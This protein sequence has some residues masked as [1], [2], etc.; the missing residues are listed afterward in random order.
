MSRSSTTITVL[1]IRALQPVRLSWPSGWVEV[2]GAAGIPPL[3]T[4]DNG[5]EQEFV[6]DPAGLLEPVV[7]EGDAEDRRPALDAPP[8]TV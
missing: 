7:E 8:D 4:V 5:V 6:P 3:L 1:S 2:P